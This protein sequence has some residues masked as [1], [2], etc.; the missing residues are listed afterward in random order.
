MGTGE[1]YVTIDALKAISA[2]TVAVNTI[3]T[4]AP[5]MRDSYKGG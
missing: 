1:M 3:T 2:K 4:L 5:I